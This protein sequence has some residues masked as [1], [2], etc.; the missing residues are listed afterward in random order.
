MANVKGTVTTAFSYKGKD[1][2]EGDEVSIDVKHASRYE[3]LNYVKFDRE[4]EKK[5]EAAVEKQKE[6]K[7]NSGPN[8][9]KTK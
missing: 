1:Y 6:K 8:A 3:G 7:D 5:V 9:P 2:K 4:T